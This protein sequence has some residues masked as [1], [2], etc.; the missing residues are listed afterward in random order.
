[1]IDGTLLDYAK[2]RETLLCLLLET[3]ATIRD[4]LMVDVDQRKVLHHGRFDD[5]SIETKTLHDGWVDLDP[6]GFKVAVE[7]LFGH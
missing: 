1:M 6:P 7:D 5:R 4:Y 3:V 2:D